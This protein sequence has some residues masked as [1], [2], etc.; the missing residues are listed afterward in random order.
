M[1]TEQKAFNKSQIDADSPKIFMDETYAKLMD[2]DN[3]KVGL[4]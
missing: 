4:Y 1:I 3:W 2:P